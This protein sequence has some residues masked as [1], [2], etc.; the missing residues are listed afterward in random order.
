MHVCKV[1]K[2]TFEGEANHLLSEGWRLESVDKT[3]TGGASGHD[4]ESVFV[5]LMPKP[6]QRPQEFDDVAF[7]ATV[8]NMRMKYS[9]LIS[10]IGEFGGVSERSAH[11]IFKTLANNFQR[12]TEGF[13]AVK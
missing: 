11:R 10:I 8:S 1:R 7:M 5:L 3:Y 4:H 9:T 12:D 6:R 13:Y 2:T